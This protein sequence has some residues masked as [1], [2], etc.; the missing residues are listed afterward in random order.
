MRYFEYLYKQIFSAV[1]APPVHTQIEFLLNKGVF[2]CFYKC[3][4]FQFNIHEDRKY[5]AF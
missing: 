4:F 3:R 2:S 1:R 5:E